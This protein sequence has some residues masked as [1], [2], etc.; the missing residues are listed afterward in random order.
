M[1]NGIPFYTIKSHFVFYLFSDNT[2]Y[3]CEVNWLIRSRDGEIMSVES[4]S[5]AAASTTRVP[6]SQLNLTTP[7]SWK[8]LL[9][10]SS[11]FFL[12]RLH[13]SVGSALS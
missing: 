6:S 7:P 2:V 10:F 12:S 13:S 3:F 11:I 8:Y 4:G 9:Q 5:Y 1:G